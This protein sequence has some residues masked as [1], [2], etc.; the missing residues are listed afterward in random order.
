MKSSPRDHFLFILVAAACFL[1]AGCAT[2]GQ[3]NVPDP[4]GVIVEGELVRPTG[5][6]L[7]HV[8]QKGAPA[9]IANDMPGTATSGRVL[10]RE[11]NDIL[12]QGSIRGP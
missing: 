5:S 3:S 8:V 7:S 12:P 4:R 9:G 11:Q 2:T 6:R 10:E 1:S